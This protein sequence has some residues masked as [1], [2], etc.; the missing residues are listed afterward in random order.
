M[1]MN[2]IFFNCKWERQ[3][4]GLAEGMIPL[5]HKWSSIANSFHLSSFRMSELLVT[6]VT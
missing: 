4:N 5:N 6:I 1:Y 2:K 3:G